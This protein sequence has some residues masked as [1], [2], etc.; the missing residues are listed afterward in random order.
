MAI[1][2]RA[3][4]GGKLIDIGP[5]KE[6][7]YGW[8]PRQ[9]R[10]PKMVSAHESI[11]ARMPRFSAARAVNETP[12]KVDLTE[13]WSHKKVVEDIGMAFPGLRQVEG[14]CVGVGLGTV[15]FTVGAIGA[16]E[17]FDL[18]KIVIP[19][20][21]VP[22]ARSRLYCGLT[23]PG[24]GSMGSTAAKA[25]LEDGCSDARAQGLPTFTTNDMLC[26]G[27][28]VEIG[29]SDGD[30][31]NIVAQL[32]ISR[33]RKCRE[34]NPVRTTDEVEQSIRS[35]CPLTTASTLIP[36]PR[37]EADG[38][39]YGRVSRSGG[40]QTSIMGV[41]RH[42]QKGLLFKYQ[43]Q[44][45]LNWGKRSACWIPAADLQAMIDDG[46]ETYSFKYH[47]G[48]LASKFSWLA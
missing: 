27:S 32:P 20:W 24:D 44:W 46:E 36:D 5:R 6:W 29:W 11:V 47:D 23:S 2:I 42:P 3:E 13:I 1:D 12:D 43:N 16:I 14:S 25:A 34:V 39:A 8:I 30:A 15:I 35:L 28:S 19:F 38:E 21:L 10:T 9:N 31:P 7:N 17:W 18:E 4:R 26:W 48:T 45:G 40:H 37:I 33:Q 22:Y 41:W